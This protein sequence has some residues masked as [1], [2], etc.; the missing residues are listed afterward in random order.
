METFYNVIAL[1]GAGKSKTIRAMADKNDAIKLAKQL[2][3]NTGVD[4][5]VTEERRIYSTRD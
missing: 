3:I 4:H 1:Y 5:G 2:Y